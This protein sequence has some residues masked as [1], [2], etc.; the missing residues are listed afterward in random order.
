[1]KKRLIIMMSCMFVV[2]PAVFGDLTTTG[3]HTQLSA[4]EPSARMCSG[5]EGVAR[6]IP[7]EMQQDSPRVTRAASSAASAEN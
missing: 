6:T 2:A 3:V 7:A 1:M 4:T 5:N